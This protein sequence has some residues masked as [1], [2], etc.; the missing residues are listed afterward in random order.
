M[1]N[2]DAA[3]GR[4]RSA[5]DD[6]SL[7]TAALDVLLASG[8]P[9]AVRQ[10]DF[11]GRAA[12]LG[13]PAASAICERLRIPWQELR[14]RA[15]TAQKEDEITPSSRAAAAPPPRA[16]SVPRHRPVL[17]A[18][19]LDRVLRSA[20]ARSDRPLLTQAEYVRVR[21]GAGPRHSMPS[22]S[23]LLRSLR[24]QRVTWHEAL[25][26]AGLPSRAASRSS[27]VM[28]WSEAI[29][30]FVDETQ[31]APTRTAV[32]RWADRRALRV[33]GRRQRLAADEWELLVGA[34]RTRLAALRQVLPKGTL[35]ISDLAG[36]CPVTPDHPYAR[37]QCWTTGRVVD[38]LVRAL[39][40]LG[41]GEQLTFQYLCVLWLAEPWVFPCPG[42]IH[43]IGTASG[44]ESP[45]ST[46]RA[47]AIQARAER[48]HDR[49]V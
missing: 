12:A 48:N 36:V 8:D 21:N 24:D 37:R 17:T 47:R 11:D 23:R 29:A 10:S 7:L 5:W 41:P 26:R 38:A 20:A 49:P 32:A 31:R 9:L 25:A 40:L 1:R 22:M 3:T 46:L 27:R 34:E 33:P 4:L 28:P 18:D 6:H 19:E 30:M 14:R 35:H 15:A 44:I 45:F 2:R 16:R 39:D 13:L 43:D 42:T